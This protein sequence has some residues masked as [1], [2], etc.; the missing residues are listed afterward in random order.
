MT[1]I[2]D[3]MTKRDRRMLQFVN[4]YCLATN[5]LFA[6][7]FFTGPHQRTNVG[8]VV[9]KLVR[10][11][12]LR[13]V[14]CGHGMSYVVLTRRGCRAIGAADRTPRPLTEQSLRWR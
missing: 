12:L 2:N 9:R 6:E 8:R 3:L 4:R 1:R 5:E 11:K 13:N 7:V 14:E 10:R